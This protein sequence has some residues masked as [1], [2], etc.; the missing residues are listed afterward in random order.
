MNSVWASQ[1]LMVMAS[2]IH[3]QVRKMD[4][5][6]ILLVVMSIVELRVPQSC[7]TMAL[8]KQR[9]LVFKHFVERTSGFVLFL[10]IC[11]RL[12]YCKLSFQERKIH[13]RTN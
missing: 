9:C 13:K 6:L 11:I 10:K 4:Q 3:V 2:L 1:M 8:L 5:L 7:V 12:R